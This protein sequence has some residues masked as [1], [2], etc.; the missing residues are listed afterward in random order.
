ML[1]SFQLSFGTG[2]QS[3][4]YLSIYLSLSLFLSLFWLYRTLPVRS[5]D[6]KNIDKRRVSRY[7]SRHTAL[8]RKTS[9][10]PSKV[11]NY[12]MKIRVMSAS[13]I[14]SSALSGKLTRIID[15][16]INA[17]WEKFR[18]E[19]HMTLSYNS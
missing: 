7:R 5:F 4:F 13:V 14:E 12:E 15:Y 19:K 3:S 18:S 2:V 6:V 11:A 17:L 8:S 1:G 10:F 9:L 16:N